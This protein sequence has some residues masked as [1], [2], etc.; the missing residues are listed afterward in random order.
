MAWAQRQHLKIE[1]QRLAGLATLL[2]NSCCSHALLG[3]CRRHLLGLGQIGKRRSVF[4][5]QSQDN[6]QGLF[7]RSPI[8]FAGRSGSQIAVTAFKIV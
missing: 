8:P 5:A 6:V 2:G 7:C 1:A 3:H 4:G